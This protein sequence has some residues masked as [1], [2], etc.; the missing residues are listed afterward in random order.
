MNRMRQLREEK[1]LSQV[2]LAMIFKT[3][4]ASIS[5]YELEKSF[6]DLDMIIK[7]AD[8][9]QVSIDYLLGR[10]PFRQSENLSLSGKEELCLNLFNHLSE[11]KKRL[12]ISYLKGLAEPE[13]K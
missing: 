9:F 12:A 6:P 13:N 2:A 8:Y 1:H 7:M 5:K 10:S 4:Q 11:T 3:T